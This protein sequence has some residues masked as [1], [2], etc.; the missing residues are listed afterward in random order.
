MRLHVRAR[1]SILVPRFDLHD[2]SPRRYTGR[3]YDSVL[4]QWVST[5]ETEEVEDIPE[6]R[7]ALQ[8]E[9]LWPADPETARISNTRFDPN[10][11]QFSKEE[12]HK[13]DFRSSRE[14]KES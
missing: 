4:N 8:Q 14:S 13:T 6:F 1:G 2:V 12:P 10:F 9:C 11:G 3:R 7:Q 5:E